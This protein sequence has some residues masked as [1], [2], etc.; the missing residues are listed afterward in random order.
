MS[1]NSTKIRAI[2]A[3]D[4][5]P[6]RDLLKEQLLSIWPDLDIVGEAENG[7]EAKQM[8]EELR[9][10]CAFLDIKMPELSG[11]EVAKETSGICRIVFITAYDQ[12][13]V[14]AFEYE[15]VDYILKP[16]TDERLAKT[17]M[18]LKAQI[19]SKSPIINMSEIFERLMLKMNTPPPQRYLQWIRVQVKENVILVPIED[20][21]F[22][23]ARD[24]YTTV[25]TKNEEYLIRKTIAELAEELDPV[26]F[27][28]I[29]RGTIV[30][31]R[32]IDKINTLPSSRGQLRLKDRPEV[33]TISRS[34]SNRFKQM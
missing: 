13:A 14:D 20:I 2:I 17:V 31:A 9:P 10:D 6:S 34:Y 19:D 29:H 26:F 12:Y 32:F 30:N 16:A 4:E 7:V 8:I 18:R 33:H 28:Q 21:Y 23:Q 24:K 15:A 22:F 11:M 27:F 25:M 3:E 5:I 1:D